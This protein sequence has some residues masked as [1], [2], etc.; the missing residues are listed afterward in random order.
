LDALSPLF[1]SPRAFLGFL[2][3]PVTVGFPPLPKRVVLC[4]CFWAFF[5]LRLLAATSLTFV[6]HVLGGGEDLGPTGLF[7]YRRHDFFPLHSCVPSFNC[8]FFLAYT[9]SFPVEAGA[10]PSGLG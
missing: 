4:G 5:L 3:P 7:P 2:P 8:A 9:S 1:S 6:S 10:F